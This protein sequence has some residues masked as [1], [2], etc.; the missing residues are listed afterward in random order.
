MYL[1]PDKSLM[2]DAETFDIDYVIKQFMLNP[3]ILHTLAFKK[4]LH[5]NSR[6]IGNPVFSALQWRR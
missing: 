1:D 6:K 3:R 2:T 4:M 5:D